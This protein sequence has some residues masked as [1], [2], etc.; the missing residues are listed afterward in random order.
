MKMSYSTSVGTWSD[1][2]TL[3]AR[4]MLAVIALIYIGSYWSG[5]LKRS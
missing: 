3:G 1:D 2:K 5:L 4:S